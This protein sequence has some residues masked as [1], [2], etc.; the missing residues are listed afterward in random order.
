LP[1]SFFAGAGAA[2]SIGLINALGTL[3]GFAGPYM[4]GASE[5]GGHFAGGLN[6]VGCTLILSAV[7]IVAMRAVTRAA[8]K[9]INS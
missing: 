1:T 3:G 4:I 6:L 9:R 2:A 7:T 5:T 8:R